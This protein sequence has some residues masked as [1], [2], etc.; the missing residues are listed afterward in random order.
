MVHVF[1]YFDT[2]K[3]DKIQNNIPQKETQLE[4]LF[5]LYL[6]ILNLIYFEHTYFTR[7]Y[8]QRN[9]LVITITTITITITTFIIAIH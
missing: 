6:S 5:T 1:I 7:N 4:F 8:L 2:E 3:R 9:T